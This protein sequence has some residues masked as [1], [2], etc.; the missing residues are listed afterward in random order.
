MSEGGEGTLECVA[1]TIHQADLTPLCE[2]HRF[3]SRLARG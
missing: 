1:G 3:Y 2:M